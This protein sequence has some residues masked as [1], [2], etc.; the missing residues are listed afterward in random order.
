MHPWTRLIGGLSCGLLII[1]SVISVLRYVEKAPFFYLGLETFFILLFLSYKLK[2]HNYLKALFFNLA[3]VVLLLGLAEAYFTWFKAPIIQGGQ[4]KIK[5]EYLQ[6][7]DYYVSDVVRGYAAGAN[8]KKRV[9]KSLGERVL[10]D[11]IYTTNRNGLRVAPHDLAERAGEEGKNYENAIF[12]GDSFTYGEGLN[13]HETLPYLFEE[14]SR[15]RYKVYNFG[16]HG[17]GPHQMLRIIETGLLEKIVVDQQPMVVIY[18]ALIEHIERVSGKMI[19]DAKVPRYK[20][21]PAGMAEYAGTFT[22]DPSLE[23][24]LKHIKALSNPKSQLLAKLTGTNRSQEDIKLFVQIVLQAKNLLEKR[25][26]ARFYVVV[27]PF[28][29]KDDGKVIDDLKKGGIDVITVD[30]IFKEYKD[31]MEKYLIEVDNH[32][33]KLANERLA[34]Y[35]LDYIK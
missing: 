11:V 12:F 20:L 9:R 6:G 1:A 31:P 30:Q 21:S 33:T 22:D 4:I 24:N 7:G 29:D 27:W 15:G 28:G 8:V 14:L 2:K 18:E 23:E 25:H 13:D 5:E 10:Y 34:R 16:F 26:K 35:L 19:W 32:P 17:Y 3:I